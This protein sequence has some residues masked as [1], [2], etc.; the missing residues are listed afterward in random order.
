M[1]I[2]QCSWHSSSLIIFFPFSFFF[3]SFCFFFVF[4]FLKNTDWLSLSERCD[5]SCNVI[6]S[7]ANLFEDSLRVHVLINHLTI[8]GC[9]QWSHL[10]FNQSSK[11]LILGFVP[12]FL[13]KNFDYSTQQENI[14]LWDRS[15]APL[16][17][18]NG[19]LHFG[20]WPNETFLI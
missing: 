11:I 14:W 12:L 15:Y 19:L 8:F 5:N 7:F 16:K 6:L 2:V 18:V 20:M 9:R 17:D 3:V 13:F 4:L 1:R 10:T